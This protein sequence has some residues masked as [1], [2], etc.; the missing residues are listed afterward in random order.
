LRSLPEISRQSSPIGS[1]LTVNKTQKTW[2][3]LVCDEYHLTSNAITVT[4]TGRS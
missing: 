1:Y 4:V 3:T 2:N